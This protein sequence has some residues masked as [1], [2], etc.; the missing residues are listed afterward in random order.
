[1]HSKFGA[2]EQSLTALLSAIDAVRK[3]LV[4]YLVSP[5]GFEPPLLLCRRIEWIAECILYR[6][7]FVNV[8]PLHQGDMIF[9]NLLNNYMC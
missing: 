8:L 4:T 6:I 1:M 7:T 2:T 5:E 3:S 9:L